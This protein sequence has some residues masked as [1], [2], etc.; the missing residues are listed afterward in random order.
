MGAWTV[1]F[2]GSFAA[3]AHAEHAPAK[4]DWYGSY[5]VRVDSTIDRADSALGVRSLSGTATITV[6]KD[7]AFYGPGGV[8]SGGLIEA[9]ASF[10]ATS[11]FDSSDGHCNESSS[12][13]FS[14]TGAHGP[15]DFGFGLGTEIRFDPTSLRDGSPAGGPASFSA[16]FD[17]DTQTSYTEPPPGDNCPPPSFSQEPTIVSFTHLA[18]PEAV[19]NRGAPEICGQLRPDG[20]LPDSGCQ[21]QRPDNIQV[22]VS[23]FGSFPGTAT[24]NF[25]SA[26]D[27]CPGD[28][29]DLHSDTPDGCP[30]FVVASIGD[31]VASGE[32]NPPYPSKAAK[33]CHRSQRAGPTVAFKALA[34]TAP[35]AHASEV[36][37]QGLLGGLNRV[38]TDRALRGDRRHRSPAGSTARSGNC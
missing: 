16:G 25:S 19:A 31:S 30:G 6:P 13:R 8:V 33:R 3:Q 28:S 2:G 34:Q 12:G 7:A 1:L 11:R 23:G 20:S 15:V 10:N 4:H 9:E 38:G 29:P 5:E 32:G 24:W 14:L 22:H 36:H 27:A 26:S 21:R 18:T 35:S 17:T 37:P